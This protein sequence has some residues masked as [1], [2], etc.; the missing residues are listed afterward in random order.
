MSRKPSHP[1]L[2][3]TVGF[4]QPAPVLCIG[5]DAAWF[6]GS[7]NDRTSQY[8]C[9]AW[10]RLEE[11]GHVH[12]SGVKRVALTGRGERD[13]QGRLTVAAIE[14]L[15]TEHSTDG[16]RVMVS[17]DAPL[18]SSDDTRKK[19]FRAC[20]R[21]F[22]DV[23]KWIDKAAGGSNGWHPNVQPGAEIPQR[24]LGIVE[25]LTSDLKLELWT[26][27]SPSHDRLVT[28]C[29]PAEAIWAAKRLGLVPGGFTPIHAKA[30]KAQG[31]V[32]LTGMQVT[33]LFHAALLD[34]F[35]H[36]TQRPHQWRD[37]VESILGWMLNDEDWK[38]GSMYR[39]GKLLDDVIDATICLATAIA[40]TTGKAHVWQDPKHPCDGHIMGPGDLLDLG[41]PD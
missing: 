5:L 8:D 34:S 22:I 4:A 17:I 21:F 38:I 23:R 13:P 14:S 33:G 32:H 37:V 26:A 1:T 19:T 31:G 10:A 18:Q 27:G 41:G 7:K 24:I 16:D 3:Q 40:F 9:L 11:D 20:E 30:Y 35:A 6:G 12:S 2:P 39:G 36:V 15:V 29:F 28:E 25:G